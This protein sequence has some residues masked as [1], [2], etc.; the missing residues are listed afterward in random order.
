[1]YS[2]RF[3]R[4]VAKFHLDEKTNQPTGSET[5][6]IFTLER[7]RPLNYPHGLKDFRNPV[8]KRRKDGLKVVVQP[9]PRSSHY[10]G[11]DDT[12]VNANIT[13]SLKV[14][15][16]GIA[17]NVDPA[18]CDHL[19]AF[20]YVSGDNNVA[21]KTDVTRFDIHIA[22]LNKEGY[23]IDTPRIPSDTLK[24]WAARAYSPEFFLTV[25]SWVANYSVP[26]DHP[27]RSPSARR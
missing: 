14:C 17:V 18:S 21:L 9:H 5:G 19:H 3:I 22:L 25:W 10:P 6:D 13:I 27:Y 8:S 24:D 11:L 1:M 16:V 2:P 20:S 23:H 15:T 7:S 26:T 12:T 4:N